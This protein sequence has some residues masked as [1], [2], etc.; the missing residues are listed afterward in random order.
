VE[1][2]VNRPAN[3]RTVVLLGGGFSD[4]EYLDLDEFLLDSHPA[5]RPRVCFVPTASGDSKGYV[6][7]FYDGLSG[8]HCERTHLELFRRSVTDLDGFLEEQDIVYVGGGNTANM[9]HIW[10]LHGLDSALRRAYAR[11]IVLSGISAGSACWFEACLTDSFGTLEP[12]NDGLGLLPGSF[13]PH[14]NSEVERPA[15]FAEAIAAGALPHG[16]ALD[17]GAAVR[18]RN[19]EVEEVYRCASSARLHTV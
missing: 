5:A 3:G 16:H 9:L 8:L 14:Y 2:D 19:E 17:D 18:Y 11:G 1:V 10:R 15:A 13:C 4:Q 12:L 7:R 6:E